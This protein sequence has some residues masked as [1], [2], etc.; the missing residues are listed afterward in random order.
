[1]RNDQQSFRRHLNSSREKVEQALK[2]LSSQKPVGVPARL[3]DAMTY[4]L[5]AGGKRI[6]PFLA[7]ES[8]RIFGV[9][10][11]DAMAIAIAVEMIHTASLVH[12]DLPCMDDDVL[13]R[14]KPTNHMV[15][16][17]GMAL[18]AGDALFL[19]GPGHAARKLEGSR[20]VPA[21]RVLPALQVILDA[22]GPSGI[23]GGQTLDT[24]EE[25]REKS[26]PWRIAYWKTAILLRACVMAPAYL[27]GASAVELK[28]LS[29]FGSH[30]GIAFQIVDDV[31]DVSGRPEQL[32]KTPG[33][34]AMQKKNSF[35]HLW[36]LEAAK[37][38]AID[39]SRR[40]KVALSGIRHDTTAL[41]GIVDYL[42]SRNA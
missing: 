7:L 19:M 29:S 10:E 2:S 22:S 26:S 5:L 20:R 37:A 14:G 33:K 21:E 12:D 27:G 38:M 41:E 13:R 34:D 18:L 24:E 35:V 31:L 25:E 8:G 32:G 36:G 11:D 4:S 15:Y 39:Q 28:S 30:L 16:G 40:A 17:E 3:W 6:R 1:M 23:C 9:H 42:E